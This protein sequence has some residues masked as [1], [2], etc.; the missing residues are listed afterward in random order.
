MRLTKLGALVIAALLLAAPLPAR[1]AA[2]WFGGEDTSMTAVGTTSGSGNEYNTSYSRTALEAGNST[3]VAD[4]PAN[5][6]VSPTF[7]STASIWVH[8]VFYANTITTTSGEQA[9]ILRSP[10]GVGRVYL[11]QTGTSGVLKLSIANAARSFTDLV[12][13]SAYSASTLTALD[14][15]VPYTCGAGDVTNIYYNTVLVGT[16]T[17]SLCTDAA[18]ALSALEV[19][20]VTNGPTGPDCSV[21]GQGTCWSQLLVANQ[22][23]RS[24]VVDTIILQG[25]G[26]TQAWTPNTLANVKKATISDSTF[27]STASAAQISEWTA[28]TAAPTGIWGVI[29]KSI[30]ARVLVSTTGPQNAEF[31]EHVSG[32]DYVV[33]SGN[34]ASLT[35]AFANYRC[36]ENVSP[37]TSTTWGIGEIFNTGGNQNSF[38]VQSLT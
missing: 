36:Q 4:P 17:G 12:T 7:A 13:L 33:C 25:S 14:M 10:D 20:G 32:T 28:P 35:N 1:A 26:A 8:A 27:V 11:R 31:M 3:T 38:G 29:S 21:T 15:Q 22:D 19:A 9:L 2:L 16:Y 23:T 18:V 6:W 37:A 34:P 30:E 5:R 24:M